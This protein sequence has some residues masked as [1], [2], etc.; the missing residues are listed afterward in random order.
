MEGRSLGR[1]NSVRHAPRRLDDIHHPEK[2]FDRHPE[3]AFDRRAQRT[4]RLRRLSDV[5]TT[6]SCRSFPSGAVPHFRQRATAVGR[7][8]CCSA[9]SQT[10]PLSSRSPRLRRERG[11]V[12]QRRCGDLPGRAAR[13]LHRGH[14]PLRQ[15]EST[16]SLAPERMPAARQLNGPTYADAI[17]TTNEFTAAFTWFLGGWPGLQ[18]G[19]ESDSCGAGQ[20]T[21]FRLQGERT[22]TRSGNVPNV[23][24]ENQA[25]TPC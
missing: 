16:A 12:T 22:S 13:G 18:A 5:P 9:G 2:A 24:C 8:H 4:L 14:R 11:G 3:K 7:G 19:E 15:G 17:V 21:G 1:S 20:G 10:C 25:R 6:R 23:R